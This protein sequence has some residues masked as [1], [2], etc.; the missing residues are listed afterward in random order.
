MAEN[1]HIMICG[2]DLELLKTRQMV[3]QSAGHHVSVTLD[4]IGKAA[5]LGSVELLIVC[6]TLSATERKVDLSTLAG[7]I[8]KAKVLCLVPNAGGA[9]EVDTYLLDSFAGPR[10]M[11]EFVKELVSA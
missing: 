5:D 10:K 4:P 8:S 6:H 7:S 1:N 2:R 3:L 11:L 9:T